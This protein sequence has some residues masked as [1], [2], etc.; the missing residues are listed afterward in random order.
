MTEFVVR[1]DGERGEP[2]VDGERL[3]PFGAVVGIAVNRDIVSTFD[4]RMPYLPGGITVEVTLR[5]PLRSVDRLT[6]LRGPHVEDVVGPTADGEREQ[7]ATV[8]PSAYFDELVAALDAPDEPNERVRAAARRLRDVVRRD[9]D[10][11]ESIPEREQLAHDNPALAQ[12]IREGVEEAEAGRTVD[13]G[14]F[15]QY[16]DDEEGGPGA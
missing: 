15:A 5:L 13:L 1:V 2:F 12:Q 14:S 16:L 10:P 11:A 3:E 6:I 7:G 9:G 8:V 4:P